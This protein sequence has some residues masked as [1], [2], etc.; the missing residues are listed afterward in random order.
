MGKRQAEPVTVNAT[1]V[2]RFARH[3]MACEFEVFLQ[4]GDRRFLADAACAVL[5]EIERLEEKLSVFVDRSEVSFVNAAAALAP[6]V[7]SPELFEILCIAARIGIETGR[8]FDVTVGALSE[9][10]RSAEARKM[11]PPEQAAMQAASTVGMSHLVLDAT[12]RTVWFDAPGVRIDLG[13]IGKG[14]AVSKSASMLREFGVRRALLSAGSSTVYAIGAP[15][16]CSGWC[17]G[18]RHPAVVEKRIGTVFLRDRAMS[19]SG[20]PAQR[21]PLVAEAFDHI[22]DPADPG[23]GAR[24]HNFAS[25]TVIA[26]DAAEADALSTAFYLRGPDLAERYCAGHSDVGALFV[27]R[28]SEDGFCTV[29]QIGNVTG[30][31]GDGAP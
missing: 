7:V 23:I 20:G 14:F 17:V 6:V 30:F 9:L 26:G 18:I 31:E 2:L 21:D 22:V 15:E 13:G 5:D 12:A 1:P 3:A 19:T 8:A 4:G 29:S 10:R 16:G 28:E 11:E 25:V 24:K 27:G